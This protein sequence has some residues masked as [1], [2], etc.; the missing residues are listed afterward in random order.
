MFDFINVKFDY[1]SNLK[2][3]INIVKFKSYLNNFNH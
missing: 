3:L 2:R 1:S